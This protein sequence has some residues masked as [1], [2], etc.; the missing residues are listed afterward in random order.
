MTTW[1]RKIIT[2]SNDGCYSAGVWYS[3]QYFQW[4]DIGNAWHW[5]VGLIGEVY[6]QC[7]RF[8]YHTPPGLACGTASS[9]LH[10]DLAP[11]FNVCASNDLAVCATLNVGRRCCAMVS[12]FF[13]SLILRKSCQLTQL[14]LAFAVGHH[15]TCTRGL[16]LSTVWVWC[17]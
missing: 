1:Y 5:W 12:W 2:R 4:Q 14:D 8:W 3:T 10:P 6:Y 9:V 16:C 17:K 15:Q 11:V 7:M 13:S